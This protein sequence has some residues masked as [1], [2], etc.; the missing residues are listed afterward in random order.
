MF[1]TISLISNLGA[2]TVLGFIYLAYIKNLRA[3]NELKDSQLKIAEQNLKLWKDK[4]FELERRS[5]EFIEKQLSERIKIREEEMNR[6][7]SDSKDQTDTIYNKNKELDSLRIS[8]EATRKF[9]NFTSVYDSD[10][11]EFIEVPSSELD[12]VNLGEICVDTASIII[13]DPWY[14]TMSE[15]QEFDDLVVRERMFEI[16]S[17]GERFC[18]DND[19]DTTPSEILALKDTSLTIGDLLKQKLINEVP[20]SGKLPAIEDSYI[21]SVGLSYTLPFLKCRHHTF[22]NG[23]VGAGLSISLGGDGFYEVKAE[24]YKGQLQR[25]IIDI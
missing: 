8:I 19:N 15:K 23:S 17:T 10:K 9:M 5:P 4:A 13:C 24:S 18:A 25:I 2:L 22:V 20:Y 1:E 16:V 6:L 21:K 3:V 11:K 14:L 12:I 7:V